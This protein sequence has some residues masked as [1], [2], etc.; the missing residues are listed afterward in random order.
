MTEAIDQVAAAISY[1]T[2]LVLSESS[3]SQSVIRGAGEF[4]GKGV[5]D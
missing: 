4:T 5:Q 3:L 1:V 2:D